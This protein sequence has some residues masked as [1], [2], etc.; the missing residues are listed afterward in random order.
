MFKKTTYFLSIPFLFLSQFI[1][2]I[3]ANEGYTLLAPIPTV[4]NSTNTSFVEYMKGL[5]TLFVGLSIVFAVIMI[6]LGGMEYILAETPFAK[7]GGKEKIMN[8]ITG[9]LLV[10]IASI[11]LHTIN[12]DL[13]NIGF[14]LQKLSK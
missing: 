4:A 6:V 8:A 12:P 2:A 3:A 14:K 7:G 5:Y 10:L 1:S 9:L 11:I 13:L